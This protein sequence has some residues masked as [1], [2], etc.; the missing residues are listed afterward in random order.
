MHV[1]F[2]EVD[3]NYIKK[4]VLSGFYASENEVV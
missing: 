4:K 2:S 1:R 3:E